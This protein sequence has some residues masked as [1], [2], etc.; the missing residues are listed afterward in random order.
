[1]STFVTMAIDTAAMEAERTYSAT[2]I[3]ASGVGKICAWKDNNKIDFIADVEK[4]TLFYQQ[5]FQLFVWPRDDR[6]F[7]HTS[8]FA[9]Y[10]LPY[11]ASQWGLNY[12]VFYL[13]SHCE[14][15]QNRI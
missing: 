2:L 14:I 13:L 12:A 6:S 3:G 11:L 15:L 7:H 1:M 10:H 4:F 9:N 8:V 5:N